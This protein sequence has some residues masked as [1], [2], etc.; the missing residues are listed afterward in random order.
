MFTIKEASARAGVSAA[1]LRAWERRFGF[2]ELRR[3]AGGHRQ[4]DLSEIEAL[5]GVNAEG[6][7][8]TL[9]AGQGFADVASHDDLAGIARCSG[10]RRP[11]L[12]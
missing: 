3:T 1:L 4:F 2:P 12:G 11:E 9:L 8:R 10:G 6:A 7:V 5:R